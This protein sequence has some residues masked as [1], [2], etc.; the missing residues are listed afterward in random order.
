VSQV[1]ARLFAESHLRIPMFVD[2]PYVKEG[3]KLYRCSMSLDE[4]RA[5]ATTLK[6]A[7]AA[8]ITYDHCPEVLKM[9]AGCRIDQFPTSYSA[10]RTPSNNYQLKQL[11]ELIVII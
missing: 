8:V 4:H 5:L 1:D 10:D 2:P 11:N 3:H 6:R 9:Y 7:R